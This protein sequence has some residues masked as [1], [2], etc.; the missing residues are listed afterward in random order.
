[1][2]AAGVAGRPCA[3]G[4]AL[5]C[6]RR[7]PALPRTRPERVGLRTARASAGEAPEPEPVEPVYGRGY[8]GSIDCYSWV[9]SHNFEEDVVQKPAQIGL[10]H[11][12][13]V[14]H[15]KRVLTLAAWTDAE[16]AVIAARARGHARADA[17]A[18]GGGTEAAPESASELQAEFK[19]AISILDC[20]LSELTDDTVLPATMRGCLTDEFWPTP[21]GDGAGAALFVLALTRVLMHSELPYACNEYAPSL[22]MDVACTTLPSAPADSVLPAMNWAQLVGHRAVVA[23][24]WAALFKDHGFDD[25]FVGRCERR[26]AALLANLCNE[27]VPAGL[28]LDGDPPVNVAV[29]KRRVG[30][31][32][33]ARLVLDGAIAANYNAKARSGGLQGKAWCVRAAC[34]I[35][36]A[37]LS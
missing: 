15:D 26:V 28:L 20:L 36:R 17:V 14:S 16:Q 10:S 22:P 19:E 11:F 29:G 7:A 1:M 34:Y 5:W 33:C 8:T 24:R 3:S 31:L 37:E 25:G 13:A 6:F 32:G 27:P 21:D 23:E 4:A 35:V 2:R 30:L 18:E 9:G 12:Y